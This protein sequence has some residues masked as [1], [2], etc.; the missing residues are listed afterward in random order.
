M[1]RGLSGHERIK[2]YRWC[3]IK[4]GVCKGKK[5][6]GWDWGTKRWVERLSES[7]IITDSKLVFLFVYPER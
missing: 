6:M 3:W 4:G 5:K 7:R 1:K 2:V